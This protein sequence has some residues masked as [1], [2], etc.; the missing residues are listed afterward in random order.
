MTTHRKAAVDVVLG[1][2]AAILVFGAVPTV[3][4]VFVGLPFPHRWTAPAVLS[5]SGL[6]DALAVITWCSWFSCA[7]SLLVTVA[8]RVRRGE[9][10]APPGSRVVDRLAVRMA[11][12]VLA[13]APALVSMTT[14]AGAALP[15]LAAAAQ[16]LPATP[17]PHT[18]QLT[19][20]G[21]AAS[22][23]PRSYTVETGD[24]LWSIAQAC[25][26]DGA[27]WGLIA[28][29]NLGRLMEDGKRFVDPAVI[30]PGWVLLV[31]VLD[32]DHGVPVTI[33]TTLPA[34]AATSSAGGA[35][36]APPR[37]SGGASSQPAPDARA[38]RDERHTSARPVGTGSHGPAEALVSGRGPSPPLPLP[39]P[40]IAAVGC[41]VLVAGLIAR[42]AR[43]AHRLASFFREEGVPIAMPTT[44]SADVA[45]AVDGFSAVPVVEWAEL[46]A[47][48][49]T[50]ALTPASPDG[51]T[52]IPVPRLVRV[53]GDGVEIR[54]D[55]PPPRPAGRWVPSG[56]SSWLLPA[57]LDP[58]GL[59]EEAERFG[60]WFSLLV[61]IGEN[62]D[63][64][65]LVPLRAG[66]CLAIVGPRASD[67]VSAARVALSSWTWH[68]DLVVT[69][70]VS[71]AAASADEAQRVAGLS[72]CSRVLFLGDDRLLPAELRAGCAVVTTR[73][74]PDAALTVLVDARAAS[75]HPY[76]VS[77]RPHLL[78]G[79]TSSAVEKLGSCPR[80]AGRGRAVSPLVHERREVPTVAVSIP[81]RSA[82]TDRGPRAEASGVDRL[83]RMA[84]GA[85]EV[86]LLCAV[87]RIDGLR[88]ELM[89]KRARRAVEVVAYLAMHS[90]DPVTG[91][92]LRTR[93]LGSS[94][95]DAA[96][97]TLFNTASA[98]RRSMG[99]DES[100]RP[101][102]PPAS[103]SGHYTLS[104]LV[105]VDAVRVAKLIDAGMEARHS[106]ESLALLREGLAQIE[107]E[108][109]AGVLTGYGWWRGEGHERR[110]ADVAVD[111]A[112]RL[113]RTAVTTGDLDLARWAIE[114]AR[115]VEPYSEAL[116]RAAMELAAAAG[117][118]RRLH[119][120]W[121]DCVRQMDDLDPGAM[122][123]DATE[124]LYVRL[125]EQLS[126]GARR[127]ERAVV[128]RA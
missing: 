64:S 111:G 67:L 35:A 60:P 66:T 59:E 28:S 24:S 91:D 26:D 23:A 97:K 73:M 43:R 1:A 85:V 116:T 114:Q 55:A 9:T 75:L 96:A 47:R 121:T 123:S 15:R 77:V 103:R 52:D 100:G 34:L 125:R 82:A 49:L 50:A 54:F 31:P 118:A 44:R 33:A 68:D 98:A 63:G 21:Q 110:I 105:T 6:F 94:E 119:V 17:G 112:C 14:P 80:E 8:W 93:V 79:D 5:W 42:R 107:G 74:V 65:W 71:T 126:A 95:A 45:T 39:L 41:G 2:S 92:R 56:A 29:A 101:L 76:G 58:S 37:A 25:Y 102:F 117:D 124:M 4:V 122:P 57:S 40:Q 46:A 69:E 104:P 99:V 20:S 32:G 36:S 115:R 3:L 30:Q 62:D 48:H 7:W 13:I 51:V 12:A 72:E 16:H 38:A 18:D 27:D 90:P 113:V 120:E 86:R 22:S 83:T 88:C 53:G 84:R 108:P 78:D 19:T 106:E 10:A 89:P 87:P 127:P 109:L 70:D 128:V 11:A 81:P 61:P